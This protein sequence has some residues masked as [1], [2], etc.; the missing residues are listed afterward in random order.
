[1]Q[2]PRSDPSRSPRGCHGPFPPS[3]GVAGLHRR[4][5]YS[6]FP[7]TIPSPTIQR[8]SLLADAYVAIMYAV[9]T[10]S[11]SHFLQNPFLRL[12]L[13][14]S[15]CDGCRRKC[16][17]A[18]G[19]HAV[20]GSAL[21]FCDRIPGRARNLST[22]IRLDTSI[23]NTTRGRRTPDAHYRVFGNWALRSPVLVD[24]RNQISRGG[25]II[26]VRSRCPEKRAGFPCVAGLWAG[27]V[28]TLSPYRGSCVW[29]EPGCSSAQAPRTSNVLNVCMY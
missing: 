16:A 28:D 2:S 3:R 7:S 19:P 14:P 18:K 11:L 1:M 12:S 25:R 4:K 22:L 23:T 5:R 9:R 29:I 10:C 8:G 26:R 27:R 24:A 6:A 13:S 17:S 15:P 21:P 20:R